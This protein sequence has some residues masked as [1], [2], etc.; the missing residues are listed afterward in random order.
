[1]PKIV[2]TC[3]CDFEIVLMTTDIIGLKEWNDGKCWYHGSKR[4]KWGEV[5]KEQGPLKNYAKFIEDMGSKQMTGKRMK[6][7]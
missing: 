2:S 4:A 5:A 3:N 7:F 1:M 6:R